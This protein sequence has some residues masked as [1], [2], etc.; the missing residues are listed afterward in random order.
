MTETQPG[1]PPP[2]R[3]LHLLE[4]DGIY[5]AEQVVLA[6]AGQ[7]AADPCFSAAIA[8]LVK[9]PMQPHAL[10][11]RAQALGI[12]ALKLTLRKLP[13]AYD[14]VRTI[15][16]LNRFDV[17]LIHAHGYKAEITA[18]IASQTYGIPVLV[19]CHLWFSESTSKWTTRMLGRIERRLYPHFPHVVAVSPQIA[20]QLR[21]WGVP[22]D[23]LSEISNG[24]ALDPP[25]SPADL[26]VIRRR[27]GAAA[28]TV[29]ILNVGR[30][31]EQKA[32]ADII[33]AARLLHGKHP[34]LRVV[35][36]GEGHL[37]EALTDQID[38]AGLGAVVR[39]MG[40]QPNVRHYL[41]A[42][43]I[44]ALPSVDEGLPIAALEAMTAGVPIVCTAVGALPTLLE[45]EKSALFVPLH[46]PA[47]LAEALERLILRPD[48][49]KEL[50]AHAQAVAR[51]TYTAEAMY[52][53]Y[54][55]IYGRLIRL[56]P[57]RRA[58]HDDTR[59]A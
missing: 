17:D 42:A 24:V 56:R 6:L 41:A 50:A 34:Q 36:L 8:V 10:H 31:A 49:R 48:L 15:Q 16:Q 28:D 46:A 45:H 3:V 32:Q 51:K 39:I 19:T 40:F 21:R 35:I 57:N 7:A 53:R 1:I 37:R 30:L 26:D 2:A 12:P 54:R 4:S 29:V 44:F 22:A 38:R 20:E 52:E 59:G 58:A 55:D 23:R 18:Y 11:D 33:E 47:A 13:F 14:L 27:I 9:D 5:G 25:P 43:D